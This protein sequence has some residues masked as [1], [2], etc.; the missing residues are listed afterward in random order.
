MARA[1]LRFASEFYSSIFIGVQPHP[2]PLLS[3]LKFKLGNPLPAPIPSDRDS[4]HDSA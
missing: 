4:N 2:A 3:V 1:R